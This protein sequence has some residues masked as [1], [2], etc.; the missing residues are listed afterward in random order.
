[1]SKFEGI[2]LNIEIAAEYSK[3][4][5]KKAPMLEET[6]ADNLDQSLLVLLSMISY[7]DRSNE[8]IEKLKPIL[9]LS[10]KNHEL[11]SKV[12]IKKRPSNLILWT[13]LLKRNMNISDFNIKEFNFNNSLKKITEQLTIINENENDTGDE[14]QYLLKNMLY[15]YE[16]SPSFQCHR[17]L[18]IFINNNIMKKHID[19]FE[20]KND[21]SIKD[22]ISICNLINT[23][24]GN[25]QEWYKA[26]YWVL[27]IE[28]LAKQTG[29]NFNKIKKFMEIVSFTKKDIEEYSKS[30]EYKNHNFNFFNNRPFYNMGN[31]C[32]IPVD[33]KLSQNLI[34]NNLYHRLKKSSNDKK[35]F[36]RDFGRAFEHYVN[37]LVVFVEKESKSYK[38]KAIS[39]FEFGNPKKLS[40]DS[41]LLFKD[42][43]INKE[44]VLVVEVKSARILDKVKRLK[45]DNEAVDKTIKKLTKDPL[46]QQIKTTKDIIESNAHNEI[47]KDKFYYFISVSMEDFPQLFE[48][49]N[50][51]INSEVLVNIKCA[52]L[53][54]FNIE[55]FEWLCKLISGKLPWSFSYLIEVH[56]NKYSN[57]SFKTFLLRLLKAEGFE[58][59]KMDEMLLDSQ[60]IVTSWGLRN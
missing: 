57:L 30:N 5:G 11:I 48:N 10:N 31:N 49:I 35:E 45:E 16:D 33:G 44:I 41:Y 37:Q 50:L 4:F 8:L 38:Y 7:K 56:R 13:E 12:K 39:E 15:V 32:Y 40:S 28:S 6:M 9:N 46:I 21:I 47:T 17:S 43:K 55:T 36:M 24:Y 22:F 51:D 29:F 42:I 1:M 19:S 54:S 58:N 26:N 59:K 3:L 34:F 20:E 25:C 52:G 53:N 18:N 14:K 2:V 60:K 23:V 27:H